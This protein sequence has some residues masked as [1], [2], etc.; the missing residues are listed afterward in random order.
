MPGAAA[1]TSPTAVPAPAGAARAAHLTV[2]DGI[3]EVSTLLLR[4][5]DARWLLILAHGAGTDLRHRQ[6]EATA[7][8]L[9]TAGIATLRYNFPFREHGKGRPDPVPVATATVRAA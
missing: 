4:P 7:Q 6:M 5:A 2:N 1:P 3:G 8:A 9:T